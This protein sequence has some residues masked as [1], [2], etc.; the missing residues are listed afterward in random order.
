[1][2]LVYMYDG[3]LSSLPRARKHS[4]VSAY[5]M[6]N[7]SHFGVQLSRAVKHTCEAESSPL[8]LHSHSSIRKGVLQNSAPCWGA[9]RRGVV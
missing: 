2:H 7:L 1:M 8:S 4:G 5:R 3:S 6:A 9:V